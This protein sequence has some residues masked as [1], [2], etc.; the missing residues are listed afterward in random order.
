MTTSRYRVAAVQFEPELGMLEENTS[1]FLELCEEAAE[2]GCRLIVSPEMVTTGYCFRNPE[3]FAPLAEPIPGPTTD[4]VARIAREHGC[5][6]V[7]GLGEV[8]LES[9]ALYNSA[10]L[11]GPRGLIGKVRKV[12]P[13]VA[14]TKYVK[15][16]DLGF[17]VWET[18]L[19]RIGLQICMDASYPESSRVAALQGADVICFPTNW[20]EER[21]PAADW[22][23]RAFE[24]GVYFIA[25]DRYGA[26]RGVQFSGGSCVI[27]P[28]GDLM[29][30][31]D[32]G[33]GIVEAEVDLERTQERQFAWARTG[34]KLKERRP[35]FYRDL[36]LSP[37]LWPMRM[38]RDLYG[39]NPLPDGGEFGVAVVQYDEISSEVKDARR[40]IEGLIGD[41]ISESDTA[42]KLMVLPELTLVS[43]PARADECAEPIPGPTSEWVAGLCKRWD[44]YVVVGLPEE[45]DG[46][47]FNTAALIGPEGVVGTYHK[48]HL[49]EVDRA[50]ATP[51]SQGFGVWDLPM[52]RIGMMIGHDAMF[53]EAGR[54][55]A[56]R[57]ADIIC[58]P[59]A[60]QGPE[61]LDLPPTKVPLKEKILNV[62][63]RGYWHLGR[64]RAAENCSYLAFAN[65]SDRDHMGWSG[66]FGP[67][68]FQFP[69][70]EAVIEGGGA[71]VISLTVDTRDYMG[72]HE[73]N[74]ARFKELIRRRRTQF[75]DLLIA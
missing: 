5:H 27:G 73:P 44:I 9:G 42:V 69:R 51:G 61:P 12:H 68:L 57:G 65:R 20:V 52:G 38:S 47:L 59:A 46:Q 60:I 41:A 54:C 19:G 15:D 70:V 50:W 10:A 56:I 43:D 53:P 22:F 63:N 74:P 2:R 45:V 75:Y 33:D 32:T 16:G 40:K 17:P 6:I 24:N 39:F 26:E 67:D 11:V 14:D 35:Q 48:I 49:S 8:D 21:A 71:R 1:R 18:E 62:S 7:V 58:V 13:F 64:V 30:L 3:E 23:T 72:S 4:R 31:Q 34:D 28:D 29:A 37:L 55:L 66:L 36:M 25:A